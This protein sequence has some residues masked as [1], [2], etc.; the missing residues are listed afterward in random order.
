MMPVG[1]AQPQRPSLHQFRLPTPRSSPVRNLPHP[2]TTASATPPTPPAS[3]P[4]GRPSSPCQDLT[5]LPPN[6]ERVVNIIREHFECYQSR[7]QTLV[8]RVVSK[9][10]AINLCNYYLSPAHFRYTLFLQTNPPTVI[11][12]PMPKAPH[13]F[14]E[15]YFSNLVTEMRMAGVLTATEANSRMRTTMDVQLPTR[16]CIP[17]PGELGPCDIK[18]A[19]AAFGP[20]WGRPFPFVVLEA[21]FSQ[22][23]DH[24]KKKGLLQDARHWLE[25][26]QGEVKCVVL[27]CID[28]YKELIQLPTGNGSEDLEGDHGLE[29]GHGIEGDHDQEMKDD[30]EIGEY[31]SGES[32]TDGSISA[33][34]NDSSGSSIKAYK[35][36]FKR[37]TSSPQLVAEY[38][39][40]FTAFIEVWRYDKHQK[41]MVQSGSRITLLPT[42]SS[43]TITLTRRDLGFRPR[44]E[45]NE[46]HMD[47][48]GLAYLLKGP[49]RQMLAYQRYTDKQKERRKLDKLDGE[50]P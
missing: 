26:S 13:S 49:A 27:V 20:T 40:P 14:A 38:T 3:S 25:Q 15:N 2:D 39:G 44:E 32:D 35:A 45:N 5:E 23:Y 41:Q 1:K 21:G 22:P 43:P 28:E 4:P 24:P 30:L 6:L 17:V 12:R 18:V 31:E 50:F 8:L 9:S 42:P 29:G 36:H 7:E 34:S 48:G 11:I 33:Q 37:F 47:L 10:V 16:E 19:D 46:Y